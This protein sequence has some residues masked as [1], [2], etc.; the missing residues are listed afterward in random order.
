MLNDFYNEVQ[1]SSSIAPYMMSSGNHEAILGFLAYRMRVS[2]TMPTAASGGGPFW[3]SWDH[4]PIHFV[5]FDIDQPYAAGTAQWAW[6]TADLAAVDRA[7]T[8]WVIAYNHYPMQCS[9]YFWCVPDSARFRALYE[10]LFNAPATKVDVFISGHV[11]AAEVLYPAVNGTL[12]QA[13]FTDISTTFN[14]MAGFPGDIEVC[15]NQ[16]VQPKPDW[17]FFRDDDVANDGG[18]FGF[19][20]FTIAND[21]HLNLRVWDAVNASVVLDLWV[22]RKFAA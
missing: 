2:P 13:N 11:H 15:C 3:Y 12:V 20:H 17:S 14:V 9:N 10:P 16:W 7:R 6:I 8:P 1:P 5:A 19:S 4:G 21:T 22:S 18:F